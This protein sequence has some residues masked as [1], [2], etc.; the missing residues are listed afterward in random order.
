MA[1]E[2]DAKLQTLILHKIGDVSSSVESANC[3]DDVICALYSLAVRLFPVDSSLLSG[4][5]HQSYT[6]QILNTQL[7]TDAERDRWRCS[8]YR[9]VAFPAMANILIYSKIEICVLD[10]SFA[11]IIYPIENSLFN[12]VLIA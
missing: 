3:V 1:G 11:L 4:A 8:F 5:I 10:F 6:T 9:G 7:Y 12:V 2:E